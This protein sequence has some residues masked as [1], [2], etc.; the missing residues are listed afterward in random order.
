MTVKVGGCEK[1]TAGIVCDGSNCG[2]GV[3]G[4]GGGVV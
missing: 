4:S 2:V 1:C 3:V